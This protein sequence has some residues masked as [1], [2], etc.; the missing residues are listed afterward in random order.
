[1]DCEEDMYP[2]TNFNHDVQWRIA[3]QSTFPYFKPTE[4]TRIHSYMFIHCLTII[5]STQVNSTPQ[6]R[7]SRASVREDNKLFVKVTQERKTGHTARTIRVHIFFTI[8]H[9]N[10]VDYSINLATHK[11]VKTTPDVR[12]RKLD[13]HQRNSLPP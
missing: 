11:Y 10:I 13:S 2:Y 6:H 8:H 12:N 1:M 4:L 5:R 7:T 3:N 9:V